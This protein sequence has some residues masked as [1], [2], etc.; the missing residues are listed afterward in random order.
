MP[1]II[2]VL[3]RGGGV[4]GPALAAVVELPTGPCPNDGPRMTGVDW[5]A[6]RFEAASEPQ[7]S[8]PQDAPALSPRVERQ[9]SRR[10][11]QTASTP[12]VIASHRCSEIFVPKYPSSPR[13]IVFIGES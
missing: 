6:P 2:Q 1:G 7:A 12:T 3:N 9:D 10:T 13:N 8:M 4:R 11:N 5:S